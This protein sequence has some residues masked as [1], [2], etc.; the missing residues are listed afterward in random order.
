MT[1]EPK[2]VKWGE[3]DR[4]GEGPRNGAWLCGK[5]QPAAPLPTAK[6]CSGSK[7]MAVVATAV[8]HVIMLCCALFRQSI[9]RNPDKYKCKRQWSNADLGV[10]NWLSGT[11]AN[12]YNMNPTR[13]GNAVA[14]VQMVAGMHAHV[15]SSSSNN[16]PE[17]LVA[18]ELPPCAAGGKVTAQ[19]LLPCGR[20]CGAGTLWSQP[21]LPF[22]LVL[23]SLFLKK[24]LL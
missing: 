4:P 13:A 23:Q 10:S 9:V 14:R 3:G 5:H 24:S 2:H 7:T 16:Y 20:P 12:I 17:S 1:Q 15:H 11:Q 18:S 21:G 8:R 22:A 19:S 6:E